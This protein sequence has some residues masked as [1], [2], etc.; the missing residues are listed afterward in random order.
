MMGQGT[1]RRAFAAGGLGAALVA[2]TGAR[3]QAY[4]ARPVTIVVPFAAGGPSDVIARLIGQSMSTTLG[5][6]FIVENVAGAGGTIG[7]ARLAKADPDGYTLL[8]HH[9]A[10]L[11]G[12]FLYK[13]LP[14]DAQ[15]LAT[16]GLINQGPMILVGKKDLPENSA[17]D[18]LARLK[19]EPDR[20]TMA[21]AGVG[22]NGHLCMLLLQQALGIKI[23]DV[24]YRGTGP[25]MNDVVG[26]QVD[27]LFDQSTTAVPQVQAK[28]VKAYA[29]TATK[30]LDVV[31]DLPTM[32]EAGLKDYEFTVWHGLYAPAGTPAP[33]VARL[34]EAL[35]AALAEPAVGQR[36][37]ALGT[38]TYPE[39]ERTPDAHQ[40][41]FAHDYALWR[42]VI[43]RSG[44]AASE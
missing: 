37:A 18:L 9:I 20:L 5:Q 38:Q 29:V 7:A 33:I 28:S 8:I 17:A 13:R 32:R 11:A 12:A 34:N 14:Y 35:R 2:G 42:D 24:A 26:G 23:P 44:A 31:P 4:P 40:R 27:L 21:H 1:T 25:A 19:A 3:A 43:G 6:P 39:A 16:L 41:R 36:F 30:R 22:S 15:T 10:L